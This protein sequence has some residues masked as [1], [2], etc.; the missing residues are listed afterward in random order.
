GVTKAALYYHFK[1]KE[2]IVRSF[3]E[4]Y[5]DR[6]DALIEWGRGQP[7]TAQTASE[8]LDRYISIV[9]ESGEVFRFMERNQA[10]LR[11]TDHG[12]HRFT[13]FRPR[14]NALIE[15]LT[16]P[17]APPRSRIR[18]ASALFAAHTSCMFFTTDALAPDAD[19]PQPL[20]SDELHKIVLELAEDLARGTGPA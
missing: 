19:Q 20:D 4:D 3:T 11:D 14:L 16:G 15:I 9:M 8:L 6:L 18:A 13:Q 12:K 10:T 17:D 5:F 7:P 2:D 1:S